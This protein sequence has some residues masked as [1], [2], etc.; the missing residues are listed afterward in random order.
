PVDGIE[1][2]VIK[3]AIEELVKHHD[4]LRAVYRN[5][6]LEILPI[7]ESRLFDFYEFDFSNESDKQL[8]VHNKCTEIQGSIDLENGPLVKIAVYELGET[9]Q[10][11]FC[12]HHLAVDGV[13]WRILAE[14]FDTA[15]GQ[16]KAGEQVSLPEKTVSFIEWSKKLKEYGSKLGDAD[17][18]YWKKVNA[19]ISEG[20]IAGNHEEE[21]T[22]FAVAEFSKE[23]T[24]HL[25][26]KSSN[27]YGAKID[28]VLIAA[29]ARAVGRITGQKKL[30]IKLEGHG[31][32]EL[33]ESVLTDRTVG[34]F[35]NIYAVSV[36]VGNDNDSSIISA[37]DSLRSV[38]S[39]G[40]GYGFTEHEEVPDICFNY[41][42]DFSG[43]KTSFFGG[44]STGADVSAENKLPDKIVMNGSI[45]D[46]A[47]AFSIMSNDKCF[48]K[49]FIDKLAREFTECVNEIACYISNNTKNEA[50][51][52]DMTADFFDDEDISFI[53]SLLD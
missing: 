15:A 35:T 41:L 14:D 25:L 5:N 46:G 47:L 21:S 34:W 20:K 8:A 49:N 17:K 6:V 7:A 1:N 31:R 29:L 30:A 53:N 42:G 10:M 52:S 23:T 39:N 19:E 16:I 36:D 38:P 18:D 27:A 40:M 12:I 43:S 48:G 45:T 26:T 2:A 37:K 9:K 44:Y 22:G 24:E 50:T 32:E 33:H 4:I 3:Q 51:S 28:E 11:M 13:S